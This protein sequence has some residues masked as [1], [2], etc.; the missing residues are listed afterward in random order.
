MLTYKIEHSFQS[1]H[2]VFYVCVLES[3]V[4]YFSL[5]AMCYCKPGIWPITSTQDPTHLSLFEMFNQT[6]FNYSQ[7]RY[8]R[9]SYWVSSVLRGSLTAGKKALVKHTW[10]A[11]VYVSSVLLEKPS[12]G[13]WLCLHSWALKIRS[14]NDD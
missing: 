4:I 14:V 7:V 13:H 11:L 12:A 1:H 8:R 10:F 6:L 9:A 5:S 3:P 2:E